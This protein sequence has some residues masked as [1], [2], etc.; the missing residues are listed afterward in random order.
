MTTI[1]IESAVT[2]I[3]FRVSP[4]FTKN[5]KAFVRP[6]ICTLFAEALLWTHSPP[7]SSKPLK[8]KLARQVFDI[9]EQFLRPSACV[10]TTD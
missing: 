3:L 5:C 1:S 9:A 6:L 8:T 2:I 4:S 7:A 10:A